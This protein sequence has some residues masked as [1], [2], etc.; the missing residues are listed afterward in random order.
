MRNLGSL[1]TASYKYQLFSVN[2]VRVV[3]PFA[4]VFPPFLKPP[5]WRLQGA[6]FCCLQVLDVDARRLSFE[7]SGAN[8]R[9]FSPSFWLCTT[10]NL[11]RVESVTR[12]LLFIQGEKLLRCAWETWGIYHLPLEVPSTRSLRL[13]LI[14]WGVHLAY[15]VARSRGLSKEQALSRHQAFQVTSKMEPCHEQ[16]QWFLKGILRHLRSRSN[17]LVSWEGS[18]K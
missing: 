14:T 18:F 16:T 3:S 2:V 1:W 10:V 6:G 9:F 5:N 8:T 11:S 4:E 15:S 12:Q 17:C 13:L 7:A